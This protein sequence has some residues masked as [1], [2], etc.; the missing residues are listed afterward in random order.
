MTNHWA[1]MQHCKA[2]LVEGSNVAENHP[3][4]YKWIRKAQEAGAVMIH[5]DPR[6]SRT[7]AG[8]DIYA[9]IRPGADA[10]LLNTMINHIIVNDLYDRDYVEIHTNALFIG[11][12]EFDF[13]DG[14]FSGFD[15][16]AHK[17]DTKTW[18]YELDATRHAKRATSLDDPKCIFTRLKTFVSR[19]TLDMGS[20]I[21]GIPAEQI[22]LIAETMAKNRPGTILYAL[23]MT[24]HTTGVQG[25][26][27]FTILQLLL[28]N[29]GKPGGGVNALRG[30]PNVQGACDMGVL[31]NY[32]PG[33]LDYPS[34]TEPTLEA[35]AAKNGTARGK[36]L[37]NTL[38]AFYGTAA[39]PENQFGY[40]WLP[41]KNPAKDY[42]IYGIFESALAKQMK[43]LWVIGQNPAVTSPNLKVVFE[44]MD[45]L[46]TLIVQ[47]IWET[48]TAAFWQRPG[49]D[50]KK[51]QTEVFL[52]P[53]AF[54]MEKNG[55]ITNSGAMVQ[56]RHKAVNA[57]GQ[58]RPDGEILDFVFRRVR[59]LV[60]NS[61]D[62]KDAIIKNA[63]WTYTT[64]EDVLR[65]M[66]GRAL[67][68]IPD[69]TLKAG[70]QVS[71][72]SDLKADGSTSSG[73]WIYA[74]VFNSSGENLSKRRDFKTDPG[75][76][77]LYPGFGWTWPNNMRVLYNRASC[78]R[79]GKPYPNTKPI[80]WW[81]EA[82]GK[83]AGYDIPDVPV[84]TDGPKTPNGQR[85]FHMNAEGVGR[86]FA[87]VYADP[88]PKS[89]QTEFEEAGQTPVSSETA[90]DG[91][92]R[93]TSYVPKDGP[94]PEMYEPVESPVENLLHPKVKSNPLLK[95]PRVK[96][97]QPIGTVKDFPYVLMT[98]TVAEHWCCGSTTRNIPWLNELVPEPMCEI[99]VSLAETLSLQS[100]DFVK[101]S[102]S[103]GEVTVKAVVT[104]RMQ[105]LKVQGTEV[106]VV[107]MPYNWGFKGLSTGASVN[108]VTIDAVDPGAG[109]QE[110]KACLVNVVKVRDRETKPAVP[111][112]RKP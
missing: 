45:N 71:K 59:D 93:D 20:Q 75:N 9:R 10:A 64:P 72:I 86:L 88:R 37:I 109:T 31:N 100:G 35:W 78:D 95:Y 77:G 82:A 103:R 28:G 38:K 33:Y 96:S 17:Y 69:T 6:F 89:A 80:V 36:Y 29:I 27:A 21:T 57:P 50:P 83:W 112:G 18:G 102:S 40:E 97:H 25:I 1:D 48:E 2:I 42:S 15:E 44:G 101:V 62:P 68:D 5:V 105:T 107:W 66:S 84:L 61:D 55:T 7:S 56:W 22:K 58:A 11:D 81:D 104:P 51:I 4:A 85:A 76:L 49:A 67:K 52:L 19:Y 12:A 79:D 94:L 108:H 87:A 74:G 26:R 14:L 99:P 92:P 23:G 54:F 3:M 46:E 16:A 8:A 24:Q 73:C 91:L 70:M 110:T 39:T 41:K 60:I 65:E 111:G 30:E 13:K 98:S 90:L 43:V 32:M 53:A 34:N 47:E 106:T 63:F